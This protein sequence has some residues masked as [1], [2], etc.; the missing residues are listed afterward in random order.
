MVTL[1]ADVLQDDMAVA[2]ARVMA[3][4]N[5]RARELGVDIVQSLIT[6]TQ[7]FDNGP[8]WRINYG[9]KDYVARRGGDLMIEVGAEDMKIKQVLRGQ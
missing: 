5:K 3:T 7:H 4:A 1:S 6:I 9:P 2:V 8:L